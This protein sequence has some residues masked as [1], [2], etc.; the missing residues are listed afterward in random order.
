MRL[1]RTSARGHLLL[2]VALAAACSACWTAAAL[3]EDGAPAAVDPS[4]FEPAAG[5]PSFRR[6]LG[7][8]ELYSRFTKARAAIGGAARLEASREPEEGEQIYRLTAESQALTLGLVIG[9]IVTEI[10]QRPLAGRDF[11]DFRT[12]LAQTMT[13]V[14]REGVSRLLVMQP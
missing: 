2:L 6:V 1:N 4:V 12:E 3:A 13:V 5:V 7:G 8:A 9:D 14:N 11:R 10:D